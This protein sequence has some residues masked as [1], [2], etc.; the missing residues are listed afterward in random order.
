MNAYQNAGLSRDPASGHKYFYRDLDINNV[1]L[2]GENLI[3]EVSIPS[4]MYES[5]TDVVWVGI[6]AFE[7]NGFDM[8]RCK[9]DYAYRM[10]EKYRFFNFYFF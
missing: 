7:E 3:I 8:A 2:E 6:E 9:N 5:L 4:Q 10:L 1:E